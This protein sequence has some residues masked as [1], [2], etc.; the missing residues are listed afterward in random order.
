MRFLKD[1]IA[2]SEFASL[3]TNSNYLYFTL[4]VVFSQLAFNTTY[5]VLLF[6]VFH[7]TSSSFAVSMLIL[8]LIF[9]QIFLSFLGGIIADH[10]DKRLIIVGGNILRALV[11]L[12]IFYFNNSLALIYIVTF[13]ISV[14]T[15]LYVPA[16]APLIPRLVNREKLVTANSVFGMGFFATVLLGYVLAGPLIQMVGRAEVFLVLSLLFAVAGLFSFLLLKKES[17][18]EKEKEEKYT[19]R[20]ANSAF[21]TQ[22]KE[23]YLLLKNVND[24]GAAFFLLAFS[25]I[26]VL[27][28]ATVVPGYAKTILN[29]PAEVLSLLLFAPAALGMIISALL[30]GSVFSKSNKDKLMN[31]GIFASSFVLCAFPFT[32]AFNGSLTLYLTLSIAFIAGF[33]NALVFV[34]SQAILQEKT[35]LGQ[36]SKIYGLLFSLVGVLS[37]PPIVIAGGLADVV[38]V[39]S[40]L[41]GMGIVVLIIGLI[42]IGFYPMRFKINV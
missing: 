11:L 13:I 23:C 8:V 41:M 22:L 18:R 20:S 3:F 39:G 7:L 9:P 19:I 36:T 25:Q 38:G 5:V 42:R 40:V 24:I 1:R 37:I 15:Q 31:Y 14:L 17:L 30:I 27:V 12:P 16:E 2:L 33:A 32:S 4:A 10:Y 28:L 26:V 21:F 35:P 29:V 34:P 6:L